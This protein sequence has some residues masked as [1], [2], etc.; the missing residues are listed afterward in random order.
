MAIDRTGI[1]SLETGAPDITYTG[2][3]GPK[4]PRA[5]SDIDKIILQHWLQQGGSYG[6]DIPE[7][8]KLEIIKMYGLDKMASAP[9]MAGGG[10]ARLGYKNGKMVTV[11]KHW[12][13]APDH[14][15]TELAY[16]TK[17]EK[18]LLVK[19]DLHNSLKDGPNKGPGGVMSLN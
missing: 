9:D 19:K 15:K 8:F 2:D 10:I 3:E 5:M 12:Q 6:D 11:P 16:I 7:E 4:D 17:A 13:S 18:D 14:P 1:S